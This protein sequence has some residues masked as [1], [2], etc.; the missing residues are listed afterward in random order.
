MFMLYFV[1]KDMPFHIVKKTLKDILREAVEMLSFQRMLSDDK[2]VPPTLLHILIHPQVPCLKG[3][4]T[5]AYNKLSYHVQENRKVL[6]IEIKPEDE[7]VLKE[8]F[9]YT[10]EQNL[11]SL[12]LGKCAHISKVSP[13]PERSS[14]W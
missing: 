3:V 12:R 4:D 8:I 9:Q 1:F 7:K 2:S 13:L 10:K 14:G 5:S 6:H 11:V